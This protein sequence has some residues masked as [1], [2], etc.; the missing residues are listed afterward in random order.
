MP[1][2][3]S[4]FFHFVKNNQLSERRLSRVV[5]VAAHRQR[6]LMIVMEDVH[7]PHNLAAIARSCD[8]FGIQEIAFTMDEENLFDPKEIGKISSASASKWLDYRIFEHGTHAALATL[9]NEGWHIMATWV[10]PE[11]KSIHEIDFTQY[12]KLALLV[13]NEHAGISQTAIELADS[14][15]YI[16]MMGM[17]ESFNVSVAAALSLFEI[18]RQRL[19]SDKDFF[20][21]EDEARKLIAD[22]VVRAIKPEHRQYLDNDAE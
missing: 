12:E 17:I 3:L 20:L 21:P 15:M 14:Y 6:G 7:N 9:K 13:G 5:N 11:A 19:A 8:A 1:K 2:F 18:T 4:E 10:N 22:F 16:P